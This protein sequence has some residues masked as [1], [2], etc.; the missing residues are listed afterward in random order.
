MPGEELPLTPSFQ[1]NLSAAQRIRLSD[2][3]A[4]TPRFDASYTSSL[5][6]ITGSVPIIEQDGY[7]VGN[8]SLMLSDQRRGWQLSVGVLN[9]F[10][11][12]YLVQGNASLATLGYAERMYA[13][14]R[15]WFAQVSITF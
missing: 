13:R 1:G 11:E 14:S 6:F 4:L 12:L 15:N 2:R 5:T 9:L 10:D 8:A 3:F 7:W